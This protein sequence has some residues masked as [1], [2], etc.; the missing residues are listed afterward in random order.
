M[1]KVSFV[2]HFTEEEKSIILANV[3][4]IDDLHDG[5]NYAVDVTDF[6]ERTANVDIEVVNE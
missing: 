6:I 2:K 5:W 4:V 1:R 3:N